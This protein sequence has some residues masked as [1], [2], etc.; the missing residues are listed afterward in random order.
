MIV[1]G[2]LTEQAIGKIFIAGIIPGLRRGRRSTASTSLYVAFAQPERVGEG[3]ATRVGQ[4]RAVAQPK[5]L[6]RDDAS[7][8]ALIVS[9]L[10]VFML[11]LRPRWAASG[12][13]SSR[14]R[15]ARA[16]APRWLCCSR[17]GRACGPTEMF[18]VVLTVGRTSA[19]MLLLL[20]CAQLYSPR[21]V[22]D[23]HHRRGRRT[24][25]SLRPGLWRGARHHGR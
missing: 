24:C 18:E 15:K 14:P 4:R 22:D 16:S 1:W 19:P 3:R 17:Y 9:T 6:R 11:M 2:V 25:S 23:R 20:F 5:Q 8:R 13:A 10:L 7:S 12:S 21:A